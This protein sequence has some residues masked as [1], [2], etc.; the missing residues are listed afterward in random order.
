MRKRLVA[1]LS[2]GLLALSTL[3]IPSS[4]AAQPADTSMAEH[5]KPTGV[6]LDGKL[7]P[8]LESRE[9]DR[10]VVE[11]A[12]KA[13]LR[14]ARDIDDFTARGR[15]VVDRLREAAQ[16][17]Q[18]DA[19]ALVR[20]T[21][22]ARGTAFWLRNAM[23]VEGDADLAARLAELPGVASVR[24]ERIYPLVKPVA[25]GAA[26]Q[27]AVGDP[28]WGVA[29]IGA[30]QAWD[31]GVVG[32]GVVVA[33]V[34]TG[35]DYTH[36]AL[37]NQYRGKL[38]DG[39]F[40]HNYNW[41]DPS[42]ICGDV[43]CDNVD[44]G[45]HVMGTMVGG[46]GPGPF[47]PDIGVAPGATWIAA[48][49]CE[50]FGC[51]EFA[52][53]SS[54]QFV[55]APT[56]LDGN[57]PDPSR[58]PDIVNNSWGG[59]PGD[60]FYLDVVT[61]W[62]AAGIIPVF[63]SGNPGPFCGAGGSPG[64]YAESFSAGATDLNDVIADFSGR[65]PS[66]F[67]KINPDV[68]APGVDVLSSV[69]GGGYAAFS[70]TSMAS[71][72]VA[73]TLALVLSSAVELIGDPTGAT[74][75]V[76]ASAL[77]IVDLSCGGDGD[78]DPNNVYGE[79]RVDALAAVN[80]AAT[81]GT[82]EG[83][84]TDVATGDPIPGAKV[85]AD[86]GERV[87]SISA[88]STGRYRMFLAAGEYVVAATA[89]GYGTTVVSGVV[90]ATDQTTVTDIA[91]DALPTFVVSGFVRQAENR[92]PI[93][94]AE[95]VAVGTP[96]PA[97][98]TDATGA[99][100]LR[101]PVGS[102]ELVASKGGC[103]EKDFGFVTVRAATRHNFFLV[104]KIDDFGHG[105]L[106]IANE[107]HEAAHQTALFGD[108]TYGRLRLPFEFPFY[109]DT[110]DRAYIATN[111]FISFEDPIWAPYF[112]EGIPNRNLPNAAV[113]PLWTDLVVD[114]DADVMYET[115]GSVPNQ[116]FVVEYQNLRP[117]GGSSR[118]DFQVKLWQNGD[119]DFLYRNN[120]N[121][122]G[123][124][125]G[126]LVGI[127][128]ATG[129]DALQF[130]LFEASIAPN[131]AYRF[132][133][134][135]TGLVSGTVIDANDGLPVVGARVAAAPSGRST[136]T[137]ADG[138]YT[139]RLV[140]GRYVLT[141]D[142]THY[143]SG[144]SRPVFIRKDRTTVVDFTLL[145]PVA[146]VTPTEIVAS[147]GL[148][149]STDVTLNISNAGSAAYQWQLFERDRGGVPPDL[150]PLDLPEGQRITRQPTWTK[151]DI[152]A[153]FVSHA[154]GVT[155]DGVLDTIITDPTGDDVGAVD[156]TT[157]RGGADNTEMSLAIDFAA[158][159]D[160]RQVVGF[161]FL[162]TDQNP[163]TG[164]PAEA[165]VG[166]PTQDVG[167]E[168]F[169]DLF[170]APDGFAF[171]VDA[172]TFNFVGEVP[173][174]HGAGSLQFDIPLDMLGGDDGELNVAMVLGD[175]FRPTDWAPD[176]G[177][178]TVLPF[179][180]APWM[181]ADPTSGALEPGESQD[182]V[183]TLGGPDTLPG[184]FSG[185][186]ALLGN[187]PRN[188][189]VLIPVE[190]VVDLPADFGQLGG[191][192]TNARA[193][194]P[195]PAAVTVFAERGGDPWVATATA[196]DTDGVYVMFVPEGTWPAEYRFEG[197]VTQTFDVTITAGASIAVDVALDPL[198]PNASVSGGPFDF[199]VAAG[200]TTSLPMEIA[201][202][203][204]LVDLTFEILEASLGGL[205]FAGHQPS[206]LPAGVTST[207]A[208][209]G[210]VATATDRQVNGH[211]VLIIQDALPWE[212]AA[213]QDVLSMNGIPFDI[214]GS[215]DMGQFDLSPYGVV[216]IS[217]DQPQVF[218]DRYMQH[219]AWFET[220]VA[221]GGYLWFGAAAWGWNGGDFTG[222][223]LPGGVTVSPVF[224]D[225]NNVV[226]PAHPIM[227]G[228]PN[229][230]SGT[231]ASHTTFGNAPEGSVLASG[232]QSGQPTLLEYAVGAGRVLAIGQTL[233]FAYAFGQDGR[234]ILE[235]GV[236]YVHDFIPFADVPWLS[237]NPSTGTLAPDGVQAVSVDVDSSG[238]EPGAYT[239][240][241]V[242]RTN[243]PLNLVIR[244]PVT[245]TVS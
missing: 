196:R 180:D 2:L 94:G 84:I 152:P 74:D 27:L 102:Y 189:T 190:F 133:V 66:V 156:I 72:H 147:A 230:F 225:F 79:G 61:A 128:N 77:D 140:P 65:G 188:P 193:G 179:R 108:D 86:N 245:L 203:G 93:A 19:L 130:S 202:T 208:P 54:G 206:E 90:V 127:E 145:A 95:V 198:W 41:W 1:V 221:G 103:M 231:S 7:I 118:V 87:F 216:F 38:G 187:D 240:L 91:L 60:P 146:V 21:P 144:M 53:L 182:V 149:E 92:K 141:V 123:D 209:A 134:V 239:A 176:D 10:F 80:L 58:R 111:G 136:V 138:R 214:I 241:L 223:V 228:V 129:T 30:D 89:F 56:D 155:F 229:P 73:G 101:L 50:D 158:D 12:A 195:V 166:L 235:N 100:S 9:T 237:T 109:G 233:E 13:D 14:P 201:N 23:V 47:T 213:L 44:H 116:A 126:A 107:W 175:F 199:S 168:Y 167:M 48:K 170:A 20:G 37:V 224:E 164:L 57:N 43:P 110:Y 33:N 131:D 171:V 3:S 85:Q 173:V 122:V 236:P 46:D 234:K 59:G 192:V 124:A 26:V 197:Y 97:A 178:G 22:G 52:L 39:S 244:V 157:V 200:E 185:D 62:R 8:A 11:F 63:A 35:V 114:E 71:P 238:L 120:D 137:D 212:S 88:D 153:G 69:T 132:T 186:L 219:Q 49:G 106:K 96:L 207:D 232:S 70:G 18:R 191:I 181:S 31:L 6:V 161:V 117:W 183:V 220:Y 159:T 112:P 119:I 154:A 34:D 113:Y 42:N 40:D 4:T 125:S 204:G 75:I 177:H 51:S 25:A 81:G 64:D 135:P 242:V 99:Y 78:G 24:P 210:W 211:P 45:T 148:S 218:Y 32:S 227:I 222:G 139:L 15:F 121:R 29:K 16:S 169:V 184:E 5:N 150:P 143:V 215:A 160:P 105:C 67:G 172:R 226:D 83:L 68:A 163:A 17:S 205:G 165:L 217:N 55:L 174:V 243:D 162:D 104:T 115:I 194:F 142:A 98:V 28:E 151:P 76:R 36:P 82:L